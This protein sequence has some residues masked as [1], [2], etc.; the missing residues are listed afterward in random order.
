M[1][2]RGLLLIASFVLIAVLGVSC[3]STKNSVSVSEQEAASVPI[4]QQDQQSQILL[5]TGT[6]SYDSVKAVYRIKVA[7]QTQIDGTLVPE[8]ASVKD[9]GKD[10]NWVQL[11]QDGTVLS[12]NGLDNP[13]VQ[14]MEYHEGNVIK[15]ETVRLKETVFFWRFQL[16]PLADKVV[17][18]NGEKEIITLDVVRK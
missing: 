12:V 3:G 1:I 4:E 7:S 15:H 16:N 17:V 6:I 10:L 2:K 18:R 5:V 8:D 9:T 11:S 13:L 14:E